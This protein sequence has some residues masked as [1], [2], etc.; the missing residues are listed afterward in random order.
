MWW[1]M[2][3]HKSQGSEF[4]HV[5]VSITP[6]TRLLSRELLYTA[7]TRA[8]SRITLIG[9]EADIR[10]AIGIHA[11][12]YSGLAEQFQSVMLSQKESLG[13]S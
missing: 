1:A 2:T 6:E 7:V 9:T 8:R 4:D 10:K 12:R 3:I 5:I 11:E 13:A